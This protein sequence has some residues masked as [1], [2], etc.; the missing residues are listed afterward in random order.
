VVQKRVSNSH[1]LG[2]EQLH[3]DIAELHARKFRQH[4]SQLSVSNSIRKEL[5]Q[6]H[7]NILK[8]PE[9]TQN[10]YDAE[11]D[12][13]RNFEAQTIWKT[14]IETEFKKLSKYKS[15]E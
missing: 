12:Y 3:F 4:I 14:Y 11:T 9:L 6:I 1:V 8:E 2:Q 13:S 15:V 10:K 5:K 7:N